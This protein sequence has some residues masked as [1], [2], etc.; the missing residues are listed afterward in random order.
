[1]SRRALARLSLAGTLAALAGCQVEW[2]R[3]HPLGCRSDEQALLRDTLYFGRAIPGGG[4]VDET[5]WQR[6]DAEVLA[7]A[8]PRGYTTLDARGHWLGDGGAPVSEASRLVV[9][10]HAR[11]AASEVA[12][13]TVVAAYR[14]RFHQQAVL[15]ERGAVCAAF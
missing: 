7:P 5:A 15:R 2:A 13:R 11:D 8:F 1:M 14:E 10:V 4:E 9:I 3:D 6:F 12:L